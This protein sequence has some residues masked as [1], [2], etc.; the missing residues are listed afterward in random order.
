MPNKIVD[1]A[2]GVLI[3]PD[4]SFFLASRPEGKVYAGYWE[5]PGGKLEA[6]ETALCALRRELH[7]ELGITITAATP[8]LVQTFTYAHATVRLHFFRVTDWEGTPHPHEKQSFSWQMPGALQVSPILPANG[9]ILRG[10]AQP[11]ILAFSNVAELGVT[12]FLQRLEQRLSLGSIRLVLREPQL[13]IPA[14]RQL[15]LQ[16]RPLMKAHRGTLILHRHTD[17]ALELGADGIHLSARD[18]AMLQQRPRG[19]DWVGT[20]THNR[21]ELETAMRL[22]VDY[23][24]LGHVKQTRSH[25]GAAPLTWQ[26]FAELAACGWPFPIYAIGG[27]QHSDIETAHQHGAHGIAMLRAC[28]E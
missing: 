3:R 9:P 18:L 21:C 13:D 7:E 22:G 1:V 26:G 24:V 10:L 15:V 14:Y 4:G 28:W 20:S 23:A 8:W 12:T 11:D 25:P 17:L 27:M 5:F 19:L 2:A 6:G 16:V